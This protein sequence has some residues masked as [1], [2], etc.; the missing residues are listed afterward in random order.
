MFFKMVGIYSSFEKFGRM[1]KSYQFVKFNKRGLK[2]EPQYVLFQSKR[3]NEE[4]IS[5]IGDCQK[6]KGK[7]KGGLLEMDC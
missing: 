4:K 6:Y 5:F 3:F 1:Q 7:I 2:S